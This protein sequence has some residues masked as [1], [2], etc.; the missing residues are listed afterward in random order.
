MGVGTGRVCGVAAAL[1]IAAAVAAAAPASADTVGNVDTTNTVGNVDNT[2]DA[3]A[4]SAAHRSARTTAVARTSRPVRPAATS[5][6]GP[7]VAAARSRNRPRLEPAPNKQP[8]AALVAAPATAPPDPITALLNNAAPQPTATQTGQTS[9]GVVSG[10]VQSN[11]PD[12]TVVTFTVSRAPT[13]GSVT[14]TPAGQYTY[15]ADP[16]LAHSGYVDSFQVAA[17]DAGSDFHIHGLAGLINLLSFGLIGVSGHVATST[18]NLRVDPF[19]NA[20]TATVS[21]GGPDPVTGTVTGQV[22]GRDPNGDALTYTGPLTTPNATVTVTP[23]GAFTYTPTPEALAAAT[24][25]QKDRFA[26]IVD[27]GYGATTSVDV[28]VPVGLSAP[29]EPL[30]TFCG[31]TL[32]PADTVFHADVSTLPVLPESDTWTRLLGGTLHASWGGAP[33]MGSTGGMP[34]NV[35]PAD[36]PGERVIFNRGYSTTGPGIED[37]LYSIPDH[38]LVEGMPDVPAWDRHLLVFQPSTCTSQELYNVANG[39]ELPAAGIQDALGNAVYAAIW[40]STWIA[41]AGGHV[42]MNSPLYPAQGWANASRLPYLPM[43]L[44]P[45]DL[46]RGS[47]DHM[48]GI[49]IA[50]DRGTG[51]TWP[52]RSGDGTGTNPDGVPMGTVL[53]LR[54]DFDISGYDASTQVVLRALQQH[55][56][57]VF[58][59]FAP[60]RDGA[61]LLA[62]SNGWNGNTYVTAQ[63]ELKTI[64]LAAFEAV[65]VLQLA[66]DPSTGWAITRRSTS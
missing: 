6:R 66:V 65:D 24:P 26:V 39:V 38:P 35:V 60:G 63:Q 16:L 43:I 29:T 14:I 46:N 19:N 21:A 8:Q 58:D 12:S 56:A 40:G 5:Q 7:R 17:S 34:V 32:M 49:A 53:R 61:G 41:E 50:K 13:R 22:N 11:D 64:P 55:G 59:S 10:V 52:A 42:D 37:T 48:L 9:T 4:P 36:R 54:A 23:A 27:D 57:V 20:P 18:V 51:Y 31:C 47:I 25:G 30:S 45:D 44:R 33:W 1:G 3:A 2:A 62:M 15:T 28:V